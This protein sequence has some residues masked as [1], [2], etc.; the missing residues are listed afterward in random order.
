MSKWREDPARA[1][2]DDPATWALVGN[3]D[4]RSLADRLFWPLVVGN[5]VLGALLIIA[6]FFVWAMR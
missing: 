1:L 6:G 2:E 3:L 5:A 4:Q